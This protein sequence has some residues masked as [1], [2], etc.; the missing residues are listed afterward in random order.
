MATYDCL[1][2]YSI[3]GVLNQSDTVVTV[4]ERDIA[5][6]GGAS[7]TVMGSICVKKGQR[8][9]LAGYAPV[10]SFRVYPLE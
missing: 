2:V 6:A 3:S 7:F 1:L 9:E 4:N 5:R 8:I 10:G